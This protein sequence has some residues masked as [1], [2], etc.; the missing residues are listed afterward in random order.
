MSLKR[1]QLPLN[2]DFTSSV[3]SR[4]QDVSDHHLLAKIK[5]LV[6]ESPIRHEAKN[7]E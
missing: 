3:E 6:H 1:G 2:H 4:H 5:K 7:D